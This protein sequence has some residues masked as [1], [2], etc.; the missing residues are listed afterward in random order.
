VFRVD[1]SRD[2]DRF[3]DLLIE[4]TLSPGQTFVV[5]ASPDAVGIGAAFFAANGESQRR[6]RVLL[7]RL[8]Q[9]QLDDLFAP[10][11]SLT[12]IATAGQ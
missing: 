12:P 7:L 9:T 6:R 3:E 11:R 5:S 1:S 2:C 4:T 10:D 8:A